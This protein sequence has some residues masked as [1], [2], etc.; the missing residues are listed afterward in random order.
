[1]QKFASALSIY[2]F[3][4][5]Y[6]QGKLLVEADFLSRLPLPIQ[7][8]IKI[9]AEIDVKAVKQESNLDFRKVAKKTEN[10][11]FLRKLLYWVKN[12]WQTDNI[13]KDYCTNIFMRDI[14]VFQSLKIVCCST[15]K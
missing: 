1:M 10:D 2:D 11:S 15:I 4:I 8:N 3:D 5:K 9:G 14:S 7:T 6:R 13:E 12:G